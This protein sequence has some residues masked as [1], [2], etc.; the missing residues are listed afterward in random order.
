MTKKIE[1][2]DVTAARRA[3]AKHEAALARSERQLIVCVCAVD[4][5][6]MARI[7]IWRD[8]I[9]QQRVLLRAAKKQLELAYY[10]DS[11]EG[12]PDAIAW[13]AANPDRAAAS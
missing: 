11:G 7:R 4:E 5:P 13:R 1:Q 10:Y 12:S 9:N 8:L 2:H 3:V 6:T